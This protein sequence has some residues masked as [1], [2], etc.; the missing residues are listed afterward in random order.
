MATDQLFTAEPPQRSGCGRFLFFLSG[1]GC[2]V[3][4]LLCC[5][6]FSL[7]LYTFGQLASFDPVRIVAVRQGIADLDVPEEFTPHQSFDLKIPLIEQ[8]LV[9]WAVYEGQDGESVLVL[10]ELGTDADEDDL[11]ELIE[12][13]KQSLRE[14]DAAPVE[15]DI[16]QSETH[17]LLIRDRP[18]RFTLARGRPRDDGDPLE[19]NVAG[20]EYWLVTGTFAGH[21]GR[22][23]LLL[24]ADAAKFDR[25]KILD[26]IGSI[27]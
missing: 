4:C 26:L 10:A 16:E 7:G 27:K 6:V 25:Q 20:R 1:C 19:E 18:A 11:E 12:R 13:L 2:L 22:G 3:F 8:R 15:I 9:S 14:N 23:V 21:Q 5:G 17:E 24:I